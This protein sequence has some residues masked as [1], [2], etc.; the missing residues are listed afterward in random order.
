MSA[1]TLAYVLHAYV[2]DALRVGWCWAAQESRTHHCFYSQVMWR[3]DCE[4]RHV[5]P[6]GM[7]RVHVA[8]YAVEALDVPADAGCWGGSAP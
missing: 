3:C 1:R 5:M 8:R 7:R 6:A 4:R 2:P